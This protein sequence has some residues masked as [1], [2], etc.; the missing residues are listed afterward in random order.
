[1]TFIASRANVHIG[2]GARTTRNLWCVLAMVAVVLLARPP[3]ARADDNDTVASGGDANPQ[4]D[5]SPGTSSGVAANPGAALGAVTELNRKALEA[6]DNLNF[7]DAKAALK[8]ALALC[9]RNGLGRDPV[10]AQTYLN[11]GVVLL[12]ADA[13]HRDVAV[14]NLRRAIQI[15]ADIKL[16]ERL[17]NPEVQQA[18]AEAQAS[19]RATQATHAPAPTGGASG[20]RHPPRGD[21][22]GEVEASAESPEDGAHPRWFIGFG[23]GSGI[24]WA[25]GTGEVSDLQLPSGFQPSSVIHLAPEIGYFVRPDLLLSLQGR[26]QFISGATSERDPSGTACGSDQICSPSHGATAVFAKATMF[27]APSG[28]RPY[29]SGA[30]GVGTIR[31]VVSLPGRT[32]CGTDPAH[33]I[34]CV[35]TAAAG[36]VLVG[37]GGGFMYE[38]GRHFALTLGASALVGVSA[39]TFH[40]DVGGGIA[41]EL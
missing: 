8:N 39:F 34:A 2:T 10:R 29:V 5:A 6:Y 13:Q 35:D 9:D 23:V 4:T 19:V 25:S 36:P 21:E 40:L 16:P 37:P 7:D 18:F 32:N 28:F 30:L 15:Q 17:A 41:V 26:I 38:L 31:H 27:F 33:P 20:A 22:E 12:A 3:V 24:G 11:L 1:M 14:A